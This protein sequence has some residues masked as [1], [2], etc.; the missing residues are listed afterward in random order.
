MA[1]RATEG[2]Q[3]AHGL[4]HAHKA[5]PKSHLVVANCYLIVGLYDGIGKR[6]VCIRVISLASPFA[7]FHSPNFPR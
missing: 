3:D 2:D 6:I 5:D 4:G 1:L 7:P